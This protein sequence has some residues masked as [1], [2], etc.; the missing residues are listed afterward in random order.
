[1]AGG[2][3]D[4]RTLLVRKQSFPDDERARLQ[5][6]ES[7]LEK[8]LN[9]IM[10]AYPRMRETYPGSFEGFWERWWQTLDD[11]L[12]DLLPEERCRSGGCLYN[13]LPMSSLEVE[14]R[15][16][17]IDEKRTRREKEALENSGYFGLEFTDVIRLHFKE[18]LA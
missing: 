12:P 10:K 6:E 8:Q 2:L 11:I 9:L 7:E 1:M 3:I 16:V 5:D 4:E 15:K 17:E 18:Y 14:K 13:D